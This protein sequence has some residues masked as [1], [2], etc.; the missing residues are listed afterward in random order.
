MN[1]YHFH[2]QQDVLH[3]NGIWM[4]CTVLMLHGFI[5][6]ETLVLLDSQSFKPPCVLF[7]RTAVRV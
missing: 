6:E 1:L 2:D 7:S 5:I 3:V 4:Q